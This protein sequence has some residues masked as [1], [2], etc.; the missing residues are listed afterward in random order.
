MA[1]YEHFS[2]SIQRKHRLKTGEDYINKTVDFTGGKAKNSFERNLNKWMYFTTWS[3]WY[4]DLFLD[5]I[6]PETG[7]ITL[8]FDQRVLLR[9]T[10]RYVSVYGVF[11]RA[12]GKCVDLNTYT[13]TE[14]GLKQLKDYISKESE[15]HIVNKETINKNG[16][17]EHC[18][19]GT[20]NGFRDTLKISTE[21]GFDNEC[22]LN[23]KL[24][25][26]GKDGMT[27]WVEAKDLKKGDYLCINR[28]NNIWGNKTDIKNINKKINIQNNEYICNTLD[29]ELSYLL[30]VVFSNKAMRMSGMI[31]IDTEDIFI[32]KKISS[33]FK[34]KFG[35]SVNE[36]KQY[37]YTID[38]EYITKL[39]SGLGYYTSLSIDKEVPTLIR[40]TTKE[41]VR[42]FIKGMF[43]CDAKNVDN[44]ILYK[45][46]NENIIDQIHLLLLNFGIVSKKRYL[47]DNIVECWELTI[48]EGELKNFRDIIGF[49]TIEKKRAL[50]ESI[51]FCS[52]IK[53]KSSI[54][55][56]QKN[57]INGV[58]KAII[59]S[60]NIGTDFFE[61]VCV[62]GKEYK[63]F[64]YKKLQFIDDKFEELGIEKNDLEVFNILSNKYFYNKI[65]R[66][67]KGK[68]ETGD[69]NMPN[70]NSWIANGIVS[71]NTFVEVLSLFLICIFYPDTT[72]SI[73]AQTQK[74][75]AKLL[76]DK[77]LEIVKF[78][79][80]LKEE[81][82]GIPSF[83]K[84]SATIVINN[85]SILDILVN[86]E[87]TK[88]Q[89]RKRMNIEESALLNKA[90]FDDSL[91]PVI[92]MPRSTVGKLRMVN[93]EEISQRINFF[94]TAGFKGSSEYERILTMVREMAENKGSYVCGSDWKLAAWYG[95]GLSI[96]QVAKKKEEMTAI[97][98]AQNYGSTWVGA[99]DHQLVNIEKLMSC[100]NLKEPE[101][102]RSDNGEYV[103]GIDVARSQKTNNNRSSISVLKID[104]KEDNSVAHI[105]LVNL[106]IISNTDSFTV[107]ATKIKKAYKLYRPKMCVVDINGL[108]VGLKDEL[109]KQQTDPITNEILGA[110]DTVSTEES[111]DI[112][113]SPQILYGLYPQQAQTKITVN[114]ADAVESGKLR[115]LVSK[116]E[117]DVSLS[118]RESVLNYVPYQQTDELFAEISNL[119]L[120]T[121]PNGSLTVEQVQKKVDKDRYT[122]IAYGIW[123]IM[124]F[125]N[126]VFDDNGLSDFFVQI[127]RKGK[128]S[129]G[130][131][132]GMSRQSLVNKIFR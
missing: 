86:S 121:N 20:Y 101:F 132:G 71:H 124:E 2:Q 43:D 103:F 75:A 24:L 53:N 4:P 6:K 88:G 16:E 89:R 40:E 91:A 25:V 7:G 84:D 18:Y 127:N 126:K 125:D 112:F 61:K 83:T 3:R 51:G 42:S 117:E 104:R 93:P 98:F 1:S 95:R 79:P 14:D 122:S 30:G 69:I 9:S 81:V 36:S 111:S 70:T 120:K 63:K 94:T 115:L 108:G 49:S 107:Q 31:S 102:E 105:S 90:L 11:P 110:W 72:V 5:Y 74:N 10:L 96:A 19:F 50:E 68:T 57:N 116:G 45:F 80:Q 118:S 44:K 52:K 41:N 78:W 113:G 48:C 27:K 33:M 76:K 123:W 21:F 128:G 34:E 130:M 39:F 26:L 82:R 58:I 65:T 62:F 22:T 99:T 35:Y 114:F 32:Y 12:Y 87:T 54:I 55:P 129:A 106:I 73:T 60:D 37:K 77:Y 28:H 13:F 17:Q 92:D 97:A 66:I 56:Y 109:L 46:S 23:H 131:G 119:K 8:D 67:T 85:N 59:E 29:S 64:N 38:S 47:G 15:Y 100:R